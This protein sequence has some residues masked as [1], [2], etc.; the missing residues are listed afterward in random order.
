MKELFDSELKEVYACVGSLVA[1]NVALTVAHCVI[2]KT[3][4]RL[5][6]R[7]G[8]WDTRTE[9]EVLPYQVGTQPV[10]SAIC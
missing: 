2:N 7:A 3:S 5:L 10:H 1:P 9:S 8:E 4:T 6:V